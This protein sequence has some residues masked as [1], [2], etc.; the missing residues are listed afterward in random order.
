MTGKPLCSVHGGGR[1]GGGGGLGSTSAANAVCGIANRLQRCLTGASQRCL[2]PEKGSGFDPGEEQNA[3]VLSRSP[4]GAGWPLG[5]RSEMRSPGTDL[6]SEIDK[7]ECLPLRHPTQDVSVGDIR[8]Y[9]SP[10]TVGLGQPTQ[11]S[12]P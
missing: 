9:Q 6:L 1:M 11:Q 10:T 8:S 3:R 4:V 2:P 5:R 7:S 12:W